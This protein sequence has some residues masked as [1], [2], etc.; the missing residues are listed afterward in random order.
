MTRDLKQERVI[1]AAPEARQLVL[2]GPG[3]GKTETVARRIVHLLGQGVKPRELLVLSFSRS[4]VATLIRRIESVAADARAHLDDLRHVSV[5][6]FDSWTFRALRLQ[7]HLPHDLLSQ[8]HNRNIASLI[9]EIRKSKGKELP[10][11]PVSVRHIVVDEFQDL[12]GV[13]GGLVLELLSWYAKPGKNSAGFTI[14]GDAAQAIY[15]FSLDSEEDEEFAQ[16]TARLLIDRV[17][18]SYGEELEEIELETNHRSATEIAELTA[19]LR[20]ILQ[21]KI[22]DEKK[23]AAV[24][25]AVGNLDGQDVE[26]AE[27]SELRKKGTIAILTHTNGEAIRVASK[28]LGKTDE[29]AAIEVS[30]QSTNRVRS[31]PAWLG[32]TLG[33]LQSSSVTRTQ[34]AKIYDHLYG[35]GKIVNYRGMS[36]PPCDIA[37]ST[38]Y[39]WTDGGVDGQQVDL[40]KLR[41]R[42][43]WIDQIPDDQVEE[44]S[45]LEIMTIHQSKGQEFD[46]VLLLDLEEQESDQEGDDEGSDPGEA[47]NVA[48]VGLSRARRTVSV[49]ERGGIYAIRPFSCGTG[50]RRRWTSWKRGWVN[51]EMG[52]PGDLSPVSFVDSELHGSPKAVAQVQERLAKESASLIGRKVVLCKHETPV[53]SNHFLYK[54]HLQKDKEADLLLGMTEPQLTFDL[55]KRLH[56]P[57]YKYSLPKRIFNLRIAGISTVT[58]PGEIPAT[59]APTW[60]KSGLWLGII[61]HGTGDFK[62]G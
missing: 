28:I 10:G 30:V 43:D 42:L 1:L 17:R 6:T 56:G 35:A 7:G 44:S 25:K 39:R 47:A 27:L 8:R 29:T 26:A 51:M 46:S 60:A 53:G 40:A 37:W 9:E 24:L 41:G 2:A 20:K 32:A 49:M 45:G 3:T 59:V 31:V 5:R 12:S 50:N 19:K 16:L 18:E 57:N 23:L 15:G 11:L 48:Y 52:L 38:L 54:V 36:I 33:P 62:T 14:L 13:R 21:G 55:L 34:F 22:S 61:L 58:A 4:A